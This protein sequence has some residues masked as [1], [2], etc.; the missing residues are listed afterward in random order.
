MKGVIIFDV[1]IVSSNLNM[2]K[3]MILKRFQISK[4]CFTNSKAEC[5]LT[6]N[7][8]SVWTMC[9]RS[10]D[11]IVVIKLTFR[12][13]SATPWIAKNSVCFSFHSLF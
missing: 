3:I 7:L 11:I 12:V 8:V 1:N 2:S 10:H 13:R 5:F 9:L 4:R 6:S